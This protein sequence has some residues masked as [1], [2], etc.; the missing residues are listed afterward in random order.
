LSVAFSPDARRLASAG[1]DKTVML[2]DVETRE[3]VHTLPGHTSQVTSVVFSPD[4]TRLASGSWDDTVR[5]WDPTTGQQVLKLECHGD[6][7]NR[8][9]FTPDGRRLASASGEDTV[10]IWDVETGLEV[11]TLRGHPSYVYSV[12]FSPDGTRLAS[13]DGAGVV[14]IWDGRPWTAEATVEREALGLLN[15]LFTK[16]LRK[17]DVLN[18]LH[19]SLAITQQTRQLALSLVDRYHEQ[20]NPETYHRESW[21]LVRQPYLNAFQYR[22]ALLQAEHACR[23]APDRQE[24]RMGLGAALYRAGRYSEALAL[25]IQAEQMHRAAAAGLALWPTPYLPALTGLWQADQLRQAIAANLAFLAL[26]H[27]R[28]GQAT[29]AQAALARLREAV[30]QARFN[31]DEETHELLREAQ[32]VLGAKAKGAEK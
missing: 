15:F 28:L 20:T 31:K 13:A 7:V 24:Y 11:L 25:L 10:I 2:W 8:L 3:K 1:E 29:Q 23:L 21:A 5:I 9:A 30:Q 19:T 16:P 26:T 22:F 18:Y 12:A 27:H 4:G 6:V 17:A 14:K 32:A